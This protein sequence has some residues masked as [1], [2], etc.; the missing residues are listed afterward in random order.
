MNE[1]E[2]MEK[3]KRAERESERNEREN[4]KDKDVLG[5]E[6]IWSKILFNF[7]KF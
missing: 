1:L 6:R 7:L 5:L 3:G 2:K 4:E